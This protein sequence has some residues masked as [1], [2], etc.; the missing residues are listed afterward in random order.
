MHLEYARSTLAHQLVVFGEA[1][2]AQAPVVV[3]DAAEEYEICW[4]QVAA[5]GVQR[6]GLLGDGPLVACEIR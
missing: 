1:Q 4:P 6:G 5:A 2:G 3:K